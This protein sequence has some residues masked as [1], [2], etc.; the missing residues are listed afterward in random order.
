MNADEFYTSADLTR[1]LPTLGQLPQFTLV[2]SE[3]AKAW[4]REHVS[5]WD[6]F[7][8]NVR[9]GNGVELVGDYS[10]ST[11]KAALDSTQKRI[12][13]VAQRADAVAIVEVKVRISLGSLGQL[14]GYNILWR[15]ENPMPLEV[16][17]ICI[18][19][20]AQPD[21]TELLQAHHIEVVLYDAI[22]RAMGSPGH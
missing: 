12:D 15:A 5:E 11:L 19:G 10:P 7:G 2:E 13:I 22:W 4:L 1:L 21:T 17:L 18:G 8:F 6:S 14:L 20:A 16:D 3:L 9:V